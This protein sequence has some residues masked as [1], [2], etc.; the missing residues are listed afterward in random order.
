MPSKAVRSA[1]P[2]SANKAVPLQVPVV[3][4]VATTVQ[5]VAVVSISQKPLFL[6][7]GPSTKMGPVRPVNDRHSAV[8]NAR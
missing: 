6:G 8:I 3:V 4:S 1:R 7:E 2:F 5:L